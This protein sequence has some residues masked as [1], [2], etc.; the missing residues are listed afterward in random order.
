MVRMPASTDRCV[1]CGQQ[2][3]D[4]PYGLVL[5]KEAYCEGC[6]RG[7]LLP[8]I[9]WKPEFLAAQY[10]EVNQ[11]SRWYST[12]LW[13]VPTAAL[14]SLAVAISSIAHI[15]EPRIRGPLF[16]LLAVLGGMLVYTCLLFSRLGGKATRHLK[17]MEALLGIFPTAIDLSEAK[18]F[19]NLPS[20]LQINGGYC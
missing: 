3:G 10:R 11:R 13:Q 12:A 14:F 2:L 20:T 17:E 9:N 4:P 5:L 16:L 6:S 8:L 7:L 19:L 1:S 15:E 18:R